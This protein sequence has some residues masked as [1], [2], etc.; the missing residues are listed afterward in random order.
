MGVIWGLSLPTTA[1]THPQKPPTT[2]KGRDYIRGGARSAAELFL[3]DALVAQDRGPGVVSGGK[4]IEAKTGNPSVKIFYGTRGAV[5]G[6]RS[7]AVRHSDHHLG[8]RPGGMGTK[9]PG[10][11]RPS[12]DENRLFPWGLSRP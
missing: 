2:A 10:H 4:L 1:F 8:S 5:P 3:R 11:R 9:S 7:G 6:R 12:T